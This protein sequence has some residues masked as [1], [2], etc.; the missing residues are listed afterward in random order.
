M[1]PDETPPKSSSAACG[2]LDLRHCDLKGGVALKADSFILRFCRRRPHAGRGACIAAGGESRRRRLS[3]GQ[4]RLALGAGF[5]LPTIAVAPHTGVRV[6]VETAGQHARR[7]TA[8]MRPWTGAT[9]T[10]GD[11]PPS[12]SVLPLELRTAPVSSGP[13]RDE[14]GAELRR[15]RGL[16]NIAL[17]ICALGVVAAINSPNA[18]AATPITYKVNSTVD[19]ADM[20]PG[21]GV[22]S[23]GS[24]SGNKCT[25]RAAILEANAHPGADTIEFIVAGPFALGIPTVND[26]TPETGDFDIMDAV[27]IRGGIGT[28]IDG[29]APPQNDPAQ[30]GMDRLFEIHP[31]ARN[32]TFENLTL[33]E[34]S[35]DGDGAAIQNWSSGVITLNTVQVLRNLAGGAG[36]I[37]NADPS[38]YEWLPM[39]PIPMPQSGRFEIIDSLFRHNSSGA[40]GAAINNVSA[41][42]ISIFNSDIV[43][44]PGP[45]VPD[46]LDPEEMIPAPGILFPDSSPI[47]NEGQFD[48]MGT[49]WIGNSR[50]ERNYSEHDGGGVANLGDGVLIVEN[51]KLT[52]N[53]SEAAG[54]GVYSNG[55]KLTIEDSTLSGNRAADGGG[56]YSVG[57]A[58][59]IGL[60]PKITITGT[61]IEDNAA[62]APTPPT[63][64][65]TVPVPAA[66]ASGGGMV[67]DGEGHAV[68][69]DVVFEGNT[70]GDDGGGLNNQGRAS[71]VVT[72]VQFVGNES[73]NEGGGMWSAS[74]RLVTIQDSDFLN[75]K[76][77]VPEPPE[78]L[79]PGEVPEPVDPNDPG[80]NTA[81]G[82]GLY[83]EGGP[84]TV[85][86]SEFTG[87]DASEE[88]GGIS[89]DN[90]GDFK[91]SDS[92]ISNN[93][94]GAD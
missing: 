34:G 13:A 8:V 37:N 49:I 38:D 33:R 93:T 54:G 3:F 32:V 67:N 64:P 40:G 25:L 18:S 52:G 79:E 66:L 27:T 74:E 63:A 7:L 46:P 4:F 11:E 19:Q 15:R 39:D 90:H 57:A 12:W 82:G 78:P 41:G 91:L 26:D 28:V 75:N 62:A 9:T 71:M 22:C 21:D 80:L 56:I 81:G 65:G 20:N 58:S 59:A 43:D 84:V 36:A 86:R 24:F 60:R 61:T 50:I 87:N 88:G 45:M 30:I 89:I 29:G 72:R 16:R 68:L 70:A 14:G 48:G 42:Y 73:H 92:L 6:R 77:G 17:A 69:T 76:G 47:A 23:T 53:T 51:S 83:T 44:N 10:A 85:T 1:N 94:A 35:V 55:G 31:S 2:S 5:G